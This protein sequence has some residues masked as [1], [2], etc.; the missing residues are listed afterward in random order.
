MDNLKC[1]SANVGAP[2]SEVDNALH[3]VSNTIDTSVMLV[4]RLASILFIEPAPGV[5]NR[6]KYVDTIPSFLSSVTCQLAQSNDILQRTCELLEE[7]I[8]RFKIR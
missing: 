2:E 3:R 7:Q 6:E 4:Q 5:E 8:G 1:V